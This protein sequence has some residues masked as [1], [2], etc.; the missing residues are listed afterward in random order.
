MSISFSDARTNLGESLA[1]RPF[2]ENGQVPLLTKIRMAKKFLFVQ[3]LKLTTKQIDTE[4]E[5]Y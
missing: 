2:E 1:M 4:N 5:I 3:Q